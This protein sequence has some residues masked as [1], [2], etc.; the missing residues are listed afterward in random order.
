MTAKKNENTRCVPDTVGK[1]TRENKMKSNKRAKFRYFLLSLVDVVANSNL[2][3][4]VDLFFSTVLC[5]YGYIC[6]YVC[7]IK[8]STSN[9]RKFIFHSVRLLLL[10]RLSVFFPLLF[11][12]FSVLPKILEHH[13]CSRVFLFQQFLVFEMI[14]YF[15]F[16]AAV[17]FRAYFFEL[18]K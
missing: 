5:E 8:R 15:V 13:S 12:S 7:C 9:G 4:S 16:S 11:S 3:A 10:L 1:K 2:I 18:W 17:A 6:V 14:F